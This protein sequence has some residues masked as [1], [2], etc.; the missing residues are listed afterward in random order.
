MFR[1]LP[2]VNLLRT[3]LRSAKDCNDPIAVRASR[4]LSYDIA[5]A[6]FHV[7][8]TYDVGSENVDDQCWSIIDIFKGWPVDFDGVLFNTLKAEE[9][10]RMADVVKF[11]LCDRRVILR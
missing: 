4:R 1:L 5:S 3:R 2:R 7:C 9:A 11:G 8:R 10:D 6:T